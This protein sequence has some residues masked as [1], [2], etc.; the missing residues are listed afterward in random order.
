M[1][2]AVRLAGFGGQGVVL[3]TYILGTAVALHA[4]QGAA[5]TQNYGPESRGGAC[6]ADLMIEDGSVGYPVVKV[7]DVMVLMSQEAANKYLHLVPKARLVLADSDLVSFEE[8]HPNVR[9][10][11]FT[12]T[13]QEL[14]KR[15]VANIVMLGVLTAQAD[16][17]GTDPME[18]AI[19][20]TVPKGTE[21]LNM[22]AFN[23]GLVLKP[24]VQVAPVAVAA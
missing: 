23:A 16:L 13:A 1:R 21:E 12:R 6:T 14:G 4:D 10:Y 3:A 15:I 11:P 18:A 9:L 22:Q 5:M 17:I 19:L 20:A 24:D 8:E 2:T 7:P